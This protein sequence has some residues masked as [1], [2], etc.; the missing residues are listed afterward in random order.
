MNNRPPLINLFNGMNRADFASIETFARVADT[1]SFR[2]AAL[3]LSIPVS[4]V[5]VHVGR[6]ES[7]LGTKLLER[8]TRRVVLTFEGQRYLEVVRPALNAMLDADRAFAG[9]AGDLRGRLRVAAPIEWGQSVLGR[10]LGGYA[11]EHPEVE[12]EVHLTE[13]RMDPV[14]NGFDIVVQSD[15]ASSPSLV[16]KKLGVPMK[17]RLLASP[18][19]IAARGTPKHPRDLVKHACLV[20][21]PPR[22]QT[23]WRLGRHSVVHRHATANSGSVCRD[24]AAAGCGIAKLPDYLGAPALAE[25]TLVEVLARF[26]PPPEQLFALYPRSPFVPARVRAF[27]TALQAHLEVWPGCLLQPRSTTSR[28]SAPQE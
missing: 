13:E 14:R 18:R 26:A 5:S 8:T 16:G 25:G 1:G 3:A 27:V 22:A 21:G 6:L 23:R 19:Y 10:V 17:Q 9:Q 2:A 11:R 7:R 24:L 12:V 28:V 20:A 4:T 15:P